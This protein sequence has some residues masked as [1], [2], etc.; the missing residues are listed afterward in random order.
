MG[1]IDFN[2][3][4]LLA[5]EPHLMSGD[6][7]CLSLPDLCIKS[8]HQSWSWLSSNLHYP[9]PVLFSL[10]LNYAVNLPARVRLTSC[11]LAAAVVLHMMFGRHT[12]SLQEVSCWCISFSILWHT[13]CQVAVPGWPP[14]SP[15]HCTGSISFLSPHDLQFLTLCLVDERTS[16]LKVW[17]LLRP[18][19]SFL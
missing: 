7:A 12:I 2:I 14:G 13:C 19:L 9:V 6:T 15:A 10:N 4:S 18:L 1:Y 17:S 3:Q 5:L 8:I 16:I 11:H